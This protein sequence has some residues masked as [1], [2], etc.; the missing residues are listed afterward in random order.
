MNKKSIEKFAIEARKLLIE[1][2]A[3]RAAY[4]GVTAGKIYEVERE[5]S[6]GIVIDGKVHNKEIR[7]QRRKLVNEINA[8]GF[9]AVMEEIAYTW[10]NRFIALRFMEVNDYLPS[11]VRV[12]SSLDPEKKQPDLLTHAYEVDLPVEREEIYRLQQDQNDEE[13]YR[14]LLIAQCNALHQ[15]LPFL[16][17]EV[18][19]YSELLFP[20]NLL[21]AGSIVRRMVEE[22]PEED[23]REVEIV[24]WMYQY[25]ISERSDE[26]FAKKRNY[27][28]EDIPPVTQKFTPAWIVKYLT[29]NSLGRLWLESHPESNLQEKWKYF[30]ES[31]PQEETVHK[32]IEDRIIKGIKPE[33]IKILDPACGSGH[34]LVYVFDVLFQIYQSLGYQEREIPAIILE[35]N[36]YGFD[37]DKRSVQLSCFA[38]TMKA[39]S[40]DRRFFTRNISPN[41][42]TIESSNELLKENLENYFGHCK[43]EEQHSIQE[44]I[45]F[46][47]DAHI[48]GFSLIRQSFDLEKIQS[49]I[50]SITDELYDFELTE[51]LKEKIANIVEISKLLN[52]RYDCIITNPPYLEPSKTNTSLKSYINNHYPKSKANMCNV[53]IEKGLFSLK[54]HGYLSIITMHSWM[55]LSSSE[56]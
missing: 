3:Q 39:R 53:F 41:V 17:E 44:F 29:E 1:Q 42:L 52:Q 49:W 27:T 50:K 35:N 2:T 11:G 26:V 34:I 28:A 15:G 21:F 45:T 30:L 25:Y 55:F 4:Y 9:D 31:C 7:E 48:Y 47:E 8:K 24:G 19:S 36:I 13:L 33:D 16:F 18:E 38:L 40:K 32:Y 51:L 20:S 10:F 43:R 46:F 22:I 5:S 23:W 37:I 56:S 54:E 12:F 6:D 14:R